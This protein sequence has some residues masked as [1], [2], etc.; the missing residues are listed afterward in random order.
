MQ[1]QW[2]QHRQSQHRQ[3]WIGLAL[4]LLILIGLQQ[5]R[6]NAQA[7]NPVLAAW[8]AAQQRGSYA[9]S[10]DMNQT[11][12]PLATIQNVGRKSRTTE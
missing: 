8:Q 4:S 3:W 12:T 9:F 1:R 10:S 11:T 2:S 7:G 5:H 6:A